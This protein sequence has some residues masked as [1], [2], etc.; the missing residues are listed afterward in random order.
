MSLFRL[1]MSHLIPQRDRSSR[2]QVIHQEH[3]P[4]YR[5]ALISH[6]NTGNCAIAVGANARHSTTWDMLRSVAETLIATCISNPVSGAF[7]GTAITQTMRGRRR[8][9]YL[10]RRQ[11]GNV[12]FPS[13]DA[14]KGLKENQETLQVAFP[15]TFEIAVYLQPAFAGPPDATCSWG[16]VASHQG[17]V[18]QCPEKAT[19][20]RPPERRLGTNGTFAGNTT[21]PLTPTS[22]VHQTVNYTDTAASTLPF[23][24]VAANELCNESSTGRMTC[25]GLG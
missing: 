25:S 9:S 12:L 11:T 14:Q 1:A 18:R 2:Y 5:V 24:P 22:D 6:R 23:K 21:D 3:I 17:D 4:I 16:V 10:G 8:S 15:P 13:T 7:G 20:L 19:P